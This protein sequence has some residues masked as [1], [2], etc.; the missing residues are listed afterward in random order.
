MSLLLFLRPPKRIDGVEPPVTPEGGHF[1]GD[2]TPQIIPT[3]RKVEEV[4]KDIKEAEKLLSEVVESDPKELNLLKK[5]EE[6][7]DRLETELVDSLE[8]LSL[9]E[10]K[11]RI[12][13]ELQL[14][15][16]LQKQKLLEL[17]FLRLKLL[18]QYDDEVLLFLALSEQ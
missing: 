13:S 8:L 6:L 10:Q 2:P 9:V 14:Y 3:D 7:L 16:E 4:K 11:D 17:E 15:L 5:Q 18:E 1:V 12:Q